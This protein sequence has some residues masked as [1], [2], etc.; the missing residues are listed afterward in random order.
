MRIEAVYL[1]AFPPF[2]DAFMEFP[3]SDKAGKLGEVHL[4]TGQNGTGKTRLLCLLAAACGNKQPLE[5]RFRTIGKAIPVVAVSDER[6]VAAWLP[7]SNLFVQEG[8]AWRS[9]ELETL[10]SGKRL[11]NPIGEFREFAQID[12]IT[13]L[14]TPMAALAFRGTSRI[15]DAEI[16]PLATL[17]F[18]GPAS[19]LSFTADSKDDALINQSVANLKM[20]AA[21]EH[22]S[23][24]PPEEARATRLIGRLEDIVSQI[25]GRAFC[26]DVTTQPS[27]RLR[28]FWGGVPMTLTQ[29]PDG[30][31]SIVG[32]LVGCVAKI[33]VQ[34]PDHPEPL[35][36]PTIL[37]LD[38][39]ETHLH[40]AWQRK[41]LPAAQAL[42]P[43][44]Q[45]FVATHSP[46]VI[47]SVNE[48]FIH[49]FRSDDNGVVTIDPPKPCSKGDSWL[50]AVEDVLGV[51]EWYD[52]ETEELLAKFRSLRDQ[53]RN[54]AGNYDE[55]MELAK[56]IAVRSPAL[57]DLMGRE[58]WQLDR[59]L[60]R[61]DR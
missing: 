36:I 2:A 3:A 34:F 49:V 8:K 59:Q 15:S 53:V 29:L 47:S 38:E 48:G 56:S 25:S 1:K 45:I 4:L 41:I 61:G 32:W 14:S 21:M 58:M 5:E 13:Q 16:Q 12:C 18:G 33:D 54:D 7:G 57:N 55:L 43:N 31:R 24:R 35:D 42:L 52:P 26:F 27:F 46:F 51:K 10:A 37:L 28:V 30:L 23:K 19:Y 6:R 50:D 40:P 44:S 11:R 60:G 39:P 17:T 20:A 9:G 22:L